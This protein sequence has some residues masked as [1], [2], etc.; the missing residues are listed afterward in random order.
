EIAPAEVRAELRGWRPPRSQRG[1]V[2]FF[3]GLSGSGK[4]TLPRALFDALLED[5]RRTLT[6]LDGDVVRRELSRGF[7]FSQADRDLNVRRIGWVA[8]EGAR[9]GG[10]AA[11]SH[12]PPHA[13]T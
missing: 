10:R 2:V 5:G 4:S 6:V 12:T 3:T 11:L 1:L 9:H 13:A 7:G 8:A